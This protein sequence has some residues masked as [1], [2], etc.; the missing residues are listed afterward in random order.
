[1]SINVR[2]MFPTD[3]ISPKLQVITLLYVLMRIE[4]RVKTMITMKR[5]IA[6]GPDLSNLH[7]NMRNRTR[8]YDLLGHLMGRIVLR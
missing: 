2:W 6:D 4:K 7:R 3:H 1:M 8:R 5:I